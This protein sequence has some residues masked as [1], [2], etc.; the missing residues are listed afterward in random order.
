MSRRAPIEPDAAVRSAITSMSASMRPAYI[1]GALG[2]LVADAVDA[3]ESDDDTALR[4]ALSRA[5][6]AVGGVDPDDDEGD[7]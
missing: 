7:S 1:V 2:V 4:R 6:G 5:A 3:Y